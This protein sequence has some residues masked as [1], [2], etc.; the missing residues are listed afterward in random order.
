MT[1]AGVLA[2]TIGL[3]MLAQ[4]T[5]SFVAR[6]IPELNSEPIRLGFHLA[7]EAITALLLLVAGIGLLTAAAWAP[8]LFLISAGM[9]LYTA[10]VSPGYFAQRGQWGWMIFFGALILLALVAVLTVLATSP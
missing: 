6:E 2:I 5:R 10:I 7:G 4:W 3:G 8:A 9:L 1:F